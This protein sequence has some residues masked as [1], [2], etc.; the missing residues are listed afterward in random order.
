MFVANN[1]NHNELLN[2][3]VDVIQENVNNF[4]V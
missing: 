1:T 2:V 3:N 4:I